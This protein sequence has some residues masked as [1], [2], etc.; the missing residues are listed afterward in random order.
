MKTVEVNIR[1][2]SL[3]AYVTLYDEGILEKLND[4]EQYDFVNFRNEHEKKSVFLGRGFC[5]TGSLTSEVS[6]DGVK[7]FSGDYFWDED[8]QGETY[9][10]KIAN[11]K[12]ENN[13]DYESCLVAPAKNSLDCANHFLRDV[14]KFKYCSLE[15]VQCYKSVDM[16][17]IEVEDDFKISDLDLILIDT[18]GGGRGSLPGSVSLADNLYSYTNLEKQVLGVKYNGQFFEF[19]GGDDEGGSNQIYWFERNGDTWAE[20]EA[21]NERIDE[22]DAG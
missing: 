12:E 6:V 1:G 5:E 10:E 7:I 22:L 20:T 21:I 2:N 8:D 3:L 16:I 9:E 17:K 13:V 18:E 15:T 11:I 19:F 14:G 4:I